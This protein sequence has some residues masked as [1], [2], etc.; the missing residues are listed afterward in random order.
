MDHEYGVAPIQ[1]A[2]CHGKATEY[3]DLLLQDALCQAGYSANAADV[4]WT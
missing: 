3:N 2:P 4:T 1:I